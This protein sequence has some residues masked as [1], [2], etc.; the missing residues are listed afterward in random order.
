MLSVIHAEY[1]K[2]SLYAES[3]YAECHYAECRYAG[4]CGAILNTPLYSMVLALS[5]IIKSSFFAISNWLRLFLALPAN[6][7]LVNG[8][9]KHSSFL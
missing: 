8:D 2:E 6:I 7:R 4:C 3:R 5:T 1:C 9:D